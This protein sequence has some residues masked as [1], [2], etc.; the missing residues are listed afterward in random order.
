M[1][2]ATVAPTVALFLILLS[3]GYSLH[4]VG[5]IC[6][7]KPPLVRVSSPFRLSPSPL[8]ISTLRSSQHTLFPPIPP[9]TPDILVLLLYLALRPPVVSALSPATPHPPRSSPNHPTSPRRRWVRPTGAWIIPPE[10]ELGVAHWAKGF[11]LGTR[12][13]C[14]LAG[15]RCCRGQGW[16]EG[17]KGGGEVLYLSQ[18]YVPVMLQGGEGRTAAAETRP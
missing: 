16:D 1:R 15:K 4:C 10:A 6:E 18:R 12:G 17:M 14:R 9:P 2:C 13:G 3:R 5:Y 8:T 7:W 11:G